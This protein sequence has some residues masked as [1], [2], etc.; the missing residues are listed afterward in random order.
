MAM[1][2][3]AFNEPGW[4]TSKS[5]VNEQPFAS[6]MVTVYTPANSPNRSSLLALKP[7]GPVH[8][9]VKGPTPPDTLRSMAPLALPWQAAVVM[10]AVAAIGNGAVSVNDVLMEQP[11]MS[12]TVTS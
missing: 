9:K 2:A 5:L 7:P 4:F 12:V 6:V 1:V 3:L 8:P 11:F 10:P